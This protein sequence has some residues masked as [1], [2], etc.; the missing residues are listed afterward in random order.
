MIFIDEPNYLFIFI[1]NI[2]YLGPNSD[3][4]KLPSPLTD[5]STRVAK[6]CTPARSTTNVCIDN[7]LFANWRTSQHFFFFFNKYFC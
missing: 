1:I 4:P 7:Y 3:T 5:V 6:F 2:Y